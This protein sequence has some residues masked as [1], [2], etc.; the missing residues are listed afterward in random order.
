MHQHLRAMFSYIC[1]SAHRNHC[2]LLKVNLF[3]KLQSSCFISSGET[4]VQA[5]TRC[6]Y[7][8]VLLDD[9]WKAE[10][11]Q[12]EQR[13]HGGGDSARQK[14]ALWYLAGSQ[15]TSGLVRP[16]HA[17]SD[18]CGIPITNFQNFPQRQLNPMLMQVVL[19]WDRE[20]KIIAGSSTKRRLIFSLVNF[21][22]DKSYSDIS[23]FLCRSSCQHARS[24]TRVPNSVIWWRWQR[25]R[26]LC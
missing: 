19:K 25:R 8:F 17:E 21:T 9:S 10:K 6:A 16:S 1:R 2:Y 15:D 3:S 23:M 12:G 11:L 7:F 5:S 22:W 26:W 18:W 24:L 20:I 13:K 4:K 14:I